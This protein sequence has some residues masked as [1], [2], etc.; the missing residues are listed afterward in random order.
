MVLKNHVSHRIMDNFFSNKIKCI[1]NKN[2]K[3]RPN[4]TGNNL[5]ILNLNIRGKLS[6][7][8]RNN[9]SYIDLSITFENT[10]FEQ[11]TT[12]K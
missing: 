4:K 9:Y 5:I 11:Q 1:E 10:V 7:I 2:L 12:I 8:R 3:V 6:I